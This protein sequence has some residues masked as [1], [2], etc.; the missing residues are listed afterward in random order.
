MVTSIGTALKGCIA[1]VP[2]GGIYCGQFKRHRD[3]GGLLTATAGI[4]PT[5]RIHTPPIAPTNTN[6]FHRKRRN[7]NG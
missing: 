7:C 5:A 3:W 4:P 6:N 1:A 2:A